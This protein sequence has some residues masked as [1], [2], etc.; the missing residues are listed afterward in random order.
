MLH[1]N[2]LP[3]CVTGVTMKAVPRSAGTALLPLPAKCR[4][5][6]PLAPNLVTSFPLDWKMKTQ[7]ALLSAVMMCPFLSTATPLGPI[8]LPAPILFCAIPRKS[9][10]SNF[11]LERV[12]RKKKMGEELPWTFHPRRRCWSTCC[13]SR[14]QLCRRSCPLWPLWGAAADPASDLWPQI[15]FWTGRRLRIP[16]SIRETAKT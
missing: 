12:Y 5:D 10:F 3:P 16:Y 14:P 15:S 1:P 8:S 4:S 13:R 2:M 7:Q 11:S 9:Q 6:V